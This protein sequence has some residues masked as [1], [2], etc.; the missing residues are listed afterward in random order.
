MK[1]AFALVS[2]FCYVLVAEP[3]TR[4]SL[5][6]RFELLF[7]PSLSAARRDYEANLRE[8]ARLSAQALDYQCSPK[9]SRGSAPKPDWNYCWFAPPFPP[10]SEVP[11]ERDVQHWLGWAPANAVRNGNELYAAWKTNAELRVKLNCVESLC[12][13]FVW[14]LSA[15]P[16]ERFIAKC[17]S[18]FIQDELKGA[19]FDCVPVVIESPNDVWVRVVTS[20]SYIRQRTMGLP[21]FDFLVVGTK[22]PS[23]ENIL[24][25]C[26]RGLA[27]PPLS[28]T[29]R[30]VSPTL[31][32]GTS[33][34]VPSRVLSGYRPRPRELATVRLDAVPATE[35]NLSYCR[36]TVST[37]LLLNNLATTSPEDWHR[38]GISQEE[39]YVLAVRK[40]LHDHLTAACA[41]SYWR[42][43]R[44]LTCG[45]SSTAILPFLAW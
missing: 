15:D 25:L 4:P 33:E 45:L 14:G 3:Q 5:K 16:N 20:L 37:T 9:S 19:P 11:K 21:D 31:V 10:I 24:K 30:R 1:S 8:A 23:L 17:R 36:M 32:F 34:Y 22:L 6:E 44:V 13:V 42:T 29:I 2:I 28:L 12:D 43:D 27:G 39:D 40:A 35:A 18:L 7:E 26:E 38:P 41:D